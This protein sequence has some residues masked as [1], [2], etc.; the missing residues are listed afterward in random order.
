ME[1]REH[2]QPEDIES[3]LHERGYDELLEEERA[4]VLRHL[5][6]REEYEAMRSLLSQVRED[7]RRQPPLV[8]DGGVREHVMSAF[9]AQQRPL[10]NIWLNSLANVFWP[11]DLVLLWRPALAIASVAVVVYAGLQVVKF[12]EAAQPQFA[13]LKTEPAKVLDKVAAPSSPEATVADPASTDVVSA[14]EQQ[15][16]SGAVA[17]PMSFDMAESETMVADEGVAAAAVEDVPLEGSRMETV[18]FTPVDAA[19]AKAEEPAAPAP[20]TVTGAA[21][22]LVT[23]NELAGNMSVANAGTR[24]RAAEVLDRRAVS[25]ARTVGNLAEQPELLALLNTGW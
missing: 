10:W 24:T 1:R 21:S 8:D 14:L 20:V 11:K 23:E 2:Y 15:R 3:L 16:T 13:E 19:A 12:N 5:N 7:D 6:G 9:R 4:F 18:Q 22:H 17:D 25:T